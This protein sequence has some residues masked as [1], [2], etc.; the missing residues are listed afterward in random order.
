MH[1]NRL[2][3]PTPFKVDFNWDRGV[4]IVLEPDGY[5]D[6]QSSLAT[7]QFRPDVPGTESVREEMNQLGIF[8]RDPMVP[9]EVQ[10][11]KALRETIRYKESLYNDAK[12]NLRNRAASMGV[13]NEDAFAETLERLGYSRLLED[14]EKLKKR[15]KMYESKVD[16]N[17]LD[18]PLHKQYDP[19]RT[20]LFLTPPKEFESEIA[21]EIFLAENPDMAS[22]QKAW[23]AQFDKTKKVEE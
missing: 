5:V 23:L 16:K 8:L 6:L 7:E 10:A 21:M 3:N 18:R 20:L 19:K 9:Y 12:N 15:L 17:I 14:I 1:S 13:Y 22:K 4:N 2:V 11:I